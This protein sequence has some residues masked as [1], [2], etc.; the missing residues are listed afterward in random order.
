MNLEKIQSLLA[1]SGIKVSQIIQ[2]SKAS[3]SYVEVAFHEEGSGFVWKGYVPYFY[4]RTGLFLAT[5]EEVSSYL[6]RI[7][8]HFSRQKISDWITAER[9][10]WE[11]ERAGRDVT[12]H[13]FF[14]LASLE[15]T[16]RFPVNDNPQRRIQD[17]KELGYTISSR[18]VGK[19]T[20][21]LLAPNLSWSYLCGQKSTDEKKSDSHSHGVRYWIAEC[22]LVRLYYSSMNSK[23]LESACS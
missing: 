2:H 15:W 11:T 23:V 3:E 14:A 1:D 5:E 12:Q 19:K 16:S 20:E 22:S 7:K 10:L 17:I 9:K 8:S 4:R 18:R 21:R 13:F 6:L